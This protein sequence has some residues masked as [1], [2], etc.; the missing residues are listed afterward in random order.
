[1]TR[2]QTSNHRRD[3][4]IQQ[5][6]TITEDGKLKLEKFE[7]QSGTTKSGITVDTSKLHVTYLESGETFELVRRQKTTIPTYFLEVTYK[8]GELER[9]YYK[10][11]EEIVLPNDPETKY[12]VV[13]IQENSATISFL[14]ANGSEKKIEIKK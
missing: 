13:D 2:H 9:Q 11:G 10:I 5:L 14:D 7:E 3:T 12:K 1:M 8:L 6:G 4:F